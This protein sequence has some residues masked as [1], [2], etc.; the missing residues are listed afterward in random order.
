MDAREL[1]PRCLE[2]VFVLSD[3][4]ERKSKRPRTQPSFC[5]V[6]PIEARKIEG[7]LFRADMGGSYGSKVDG[8]T[9]WLCFVCF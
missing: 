5:G 7:V 4:G 8:W 1:R 2:G 9:W 6:G 3:S